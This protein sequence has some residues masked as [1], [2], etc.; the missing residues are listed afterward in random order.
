MKKHINFKKD[1][2][3]K[4]LLF[5]II[6]L[7]LLSALLIGK[8]YL[9]TADTYEIHYKI[10]LININHKLNLF[11]NRIYKKAMFLKNFRKVDLR[12]FLKSDDDIDFICFLGKN[13]ELINSEVKSG[14][15]LPE[16]IIEKLYKLYKSTGKAFF[17]HIAI[18]NK[19]Q[20]ISYV[21]NTDRGLCILNVNLKEMLGYINFIKKN[22]KFQIAIVDKEGNYIFCTSNHID[23]KKP[24]FESEIYKKTVKTHKEFEYFEFYNSKMEM[25]NF[26]MYAKNKRLNW[27][28]F[29]IDESEALDDR[30]LMMIGWT[31]LFVLTIILFIL[32]ISEKFV[33]KILNPLEELVLKMETF[34]NSRS[35]QKLNIDSEYIFFKK[36]SNSF[37]KMQD[38]ILKREQELDDLNKTLEKRVQEEV[39][40][41]R[42]KDQQLINQSR[43]AQMGEMLSMIAHQ[44]RQ[45]LSAISSL[46]GKI[47]IN[48]KLKKLDYQTAIE[49][50]EKISMYTQHLSSTIDDF[51]NFFKG[52]KKKKRTTYSEIVEQVLMILEISIKN[53]NIE[54]IKEL[55]SEKEFY[56][57]ANEIKQVVLNLVKNAEDV[58][59]ERK[60][61]NPR[62]IIRSKDNV[63]TVED[64]AGGI[65]EDIKDRIFDPYFSTKEK[66]DGT[67]LGLYMSK[68]I[69]KD[70]CGGNLTAENSKEGAIFKIEL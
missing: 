63:L 32:F 30:L 11:I 47:Y 14:I 56:T 31:V 51:R 54:L 44:W 29:V 7:L 9:L 25:D 42:L 5:S 55:K 22:E 66:K 67:G 68:I 15:V 1:I 61:Q 49:L 62:I 33:K 59:V 19:L 70:H 58:L 27:I 20:T 65:P 23:K 34:A 52:D 4:I 16:K 18:D 12:T 57:Y 10:T 50:S 17:Y 8:I 13:G 48:A 3:R 39:E 24:F 69:I 41:N 46:S 26:F 38:K 45:P 64:N 2:K 53:K 35:T 36:L 37:N 21:F 28:I 40:K 60:I 43:L 6:P